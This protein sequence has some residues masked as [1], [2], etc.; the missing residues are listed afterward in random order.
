[1]EDFETICGGYFQGGWETYRKFI[2]AGMNSSLTET[3]YFRIPVFK[4]GYMVVL[5]LWGPGAETAIHDHGGARGS[6]K[7]LKGKLVESRYRFRNPVLEKYSEITANPG[8]VLEVSATDIHAISN[9]QNE[10]SASLHIYSTDSASLEGTV[11]YDA[12]NK[13]IGILNQH[14]TRASWR[15]KPEAFMSIRGFDDQQP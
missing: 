8:E 2:P 15:E 5:M 12:V 9:P 10:M 1:M 14:A 11:I 6:V 4:G 7:V 3:E 13:R